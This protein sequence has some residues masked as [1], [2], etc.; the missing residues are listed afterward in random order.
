MNTMAPLSSDHALQPRKRLAQLLRE[1]AR[2][3]KATHPTSLAQRGIWYMQ[4]T[5]P[6]SRAYHVSFC[7]RIVSAIDAGCAR[8]ALQLLVDRHAM[9]RTTFHHRGQELEMDVHGAGE[10]VFKEIDASGWDDDALHAEAEAALHEP[11]DLTNGPL[12]RMTLFTRGDNDHV[13]LLVLHHLICEGWSL[14]IVLQEFI[15]LYEAETL[16]RPNKLPPKRVDFDQYVTRQQ[17]WLSSP[18]A[19]ASR[20]YWLDHLA[21]ELPELDLPSD[22][23]RQPGVAGRQQVYNFSVETKLYRQLNRVAQSCGI[24]LSTLLLAAYQVFLMRISGQ[25]DVSVGLPMAGRSEAGYEGVVGH[26]VNLVAIRTNLQDNLSFRALASQVWASLQHAMEHQEFPFLELVR[27]LQPVGRNGQTPIF[28]SFLNILKPQAGDPISATLAPQAKALPWGPLRIEGFPVEPLEEAYDLAFRIVE[29]NEKLLVKVQYDASMFSETSVELLCE[30]FEELLRSI[31][32]DPDCGVRQLTLLPG[33][34]RQQMLASWNATAR[35]LDEPAVMANLLAAQVR[36]SPDAIAL[37]AGGQ[38]LSYAEV[39]HRATQVAQ[40]LVARGL[41]PGDVVAICAKRS[42]ALIDAILGCVKAGV[43]YVPID[44]RY[45]QDRIDYVVADCGAQLI[46]TTVEDAAILSG[47]TGVPL[48]KLD[49]DGVLQRSGADSLSQSTQ[50]HDLAYIIYTS[51]STGHPKGVQI[52]NCALVNFVRAMADLFPICEQDTLL[53]VTTPAF[54]IFG[55]ELYLPLIVG[56]RIELATDDEARDGKR[57]ADRIVDCNVTYMQA[58]PATWRMLLSA[59]FE[60]KS[61]L[62]GLCGGEALEPGLARRM[63]AAGI[64]LWNMYGPTE[65]TIWSC[66]QHVTDVDGASVSIGRPIA[67]TQIYVL[68]RFLEPVPIGV[69]GKLYIG[70]LGL[71]RGYL[72][73]AELTAEKFVPSPFSGGSDRLYDTGDLARFLSDGRLECL[74]RVDHQVKVRGYRIELE[75]IEAALAEHPDVQQAI[76]VVDSTQVDAAHLVAFVQERPGAKRLD[77]RNLRSWLKKSLPDYMV[78]SESLSV[79]VFPQTPNGKIDRKAMVPAR[80]RSTA[81]A[82]LSD[83]VQAE[84]LPNE[85]FLLEIWQSLLGID[86]ISIDDNFFE[87]G[88]HSLLAAKMIA[89]LEGYHHRTLSIALL[90]QSPTIRLLAKAIEEL[91]TLNPG[92]C[93]FTFRVGDDSAPLILMPSMAGTAL[94]WRRFV[95]SFESERPV[96]GIYIAG[97]P[98]YNEDTSLEEMARNCAKLIVEAYPGRA[99]HLLGYSFGG[100]LAFE[101]ARQLEGLGCRA[102]IAAILDKG[103]NPLGQSRAGVLAIAKN[104]AIRGFRALI[105]GPPIKK[106]TTILWLMKIARKRVFG[107]DALMQEYIFGDDEIPDRSRRLL[108]WFTELESRYTP[109][110]Y[111]GDVLVIRASKRPLWGP[112]DHDLGWSEFVTGT[113]SV[114]I[115][116]GGHSEM[117]EPRQMEKITHL[118]SNSFNKLDQPNAPASV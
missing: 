49:Q 50:P 4:Q 9:L 28:R 10:A 97:E 35:E 81:V 72:N 74:G 118:L 30:T 76:A 86:E 26:F 8:E 21:G 95:A 15:E 71:A 23:G 40:S 104:L 73:R 29:A 6:T 69:V 31:A 101:V 112:F 78:P 61:D 87:I 62:T 65:T 39:D 17:S 51:G 111:D 45:P 99:C 54:D 91:P 98:D 115:L 34:L 89:Q 88:G 2:H 84:L 114:G 16:S 109:Q 68:D 46:L 13:L 11:F 106:I 59:G 82:Q 75:E 36:R 41:G 67:N 66:A 52:S 55:L 105:S 25:D 12:V 60:A 1:K 58:T 43:A 83:W 20:S 110:P 100:T 53:S 5:D 42:V 22:R 38:Q 107:H 32:A 24:T 48:L 18:A 57:L 63:L 80:Y 92:P 85:Q 94:H 56:A 116:E 37:S 117:L 77:T 93:L 102:G 108:A 103:P 7:M 33:A 113:V 27:I 19:D 96:V 14:G 90:A 70:G 44:P 3:T 79:D 47:S 64:D